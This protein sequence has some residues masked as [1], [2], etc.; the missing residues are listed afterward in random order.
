MC[1]F[2]IVSEVKTRDFF[3]K[4]QLSTFSFEVLS[5]YLSENIDL[6]KLISRSRSYSSVQKIAELFY[7]LNSSQ[8]QLQSLVMYLQ[9]LVLYLQ[10]LVMFL[11]SLVMCWQSL[12]MYLPSPPPM[13]NHSG[14]K[15]VA[16]TLQLI[17]ASLTM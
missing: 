14:P 13:L 16:P 10:S 7:Q 9:S 8:I 11:Q 6:P 17:A 4:I 1:I 12:A 3:R 15:V 5:H 2:V